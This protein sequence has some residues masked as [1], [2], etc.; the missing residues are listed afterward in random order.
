[1]SVIGVAAEES[2]VLKSAMMPVKLACVLQHAHNHTVP[3]SQG[4]KGRK[5]GQDSVRGKDDG[6]E[7]GGNAR[8]AGLHTVLLKT[9]NDMRR[10]QLILG[11]IR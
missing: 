3:A 10:D 6:E 11:C 1:V 5:E 4:G 9:S 8:G 2:T 7:G